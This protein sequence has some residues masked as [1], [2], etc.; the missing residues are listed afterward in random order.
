[1]LVD[2]DDSGRAAS[3]L[4]ERGFAPR[5]SGPEFVYLEID[6]RDAPPAVAA[7]SSNG[8]AVYHAQR[9]VETLENLFIQATGGETVG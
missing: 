7:L 8:I 6:E 9:R 2:V 1:M 3:L 5:V 4:Y